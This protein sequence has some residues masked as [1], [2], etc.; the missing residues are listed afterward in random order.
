MRQAS[1]MLLMGVALGS[2]L[3]LAS[4]RLIGGFLYGVSAHDG[5]TLV[6]AA[7]LLLIS[8]LAAAYLPAQR[9]AGADPMEALRAE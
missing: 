1:A 5:E 8:G 9:A 3:A 4:G 2:G 6:G 7:V